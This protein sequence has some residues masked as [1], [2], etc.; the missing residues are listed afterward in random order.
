MAERLV[1]AWECNRCEYVWAKK[2]DDKG[3]VK[4]V[5]VC[6]PDCSSPY[7]NKKRM[8]KKR[9]VQNNGDE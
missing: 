6:C 8:Y 9:G 7:W 5:P 1:K 2:T 4:S 3:M